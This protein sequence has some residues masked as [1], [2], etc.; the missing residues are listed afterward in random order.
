M[1]NDKNERLDTSRKS[2]LRGSLSV[3]AVAITQFWTVAHAADS[4]G[5]DTSVATAEG[6]A[7][8][9][10][11]SSPSA[12]A[13]DDVQE[14]TVTAQ[15]RS[16]RLTDVPIT[17]GVASGAQLQAAGITDTADLPVVT[18]GLRMDR[19]GVYLQ[20]SIRGVTA[21]ST[22]P[23]AEANVSL[24]VDGIYQPNQAANNIDLPD[25]ERVEVLK[26]PQGTLFGRNSTGGAIPV[27]TRDPS[28]TPTGNLT[29]GY[30]RFNDYLC[31]G[32]F[33]GPL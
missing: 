18:P 4:T 29:V 17:I 26:G 7:D 2:P 25:T 13:G 1:A 21:A 5:L 12:D 14:I 30:G 27:F 19:L 32:F 11:G 31:H 6:G 10:A 22:A 24:Y 16:E 15:R 33:L 23:G 9:A 28:F 3:A 20:P 8:I